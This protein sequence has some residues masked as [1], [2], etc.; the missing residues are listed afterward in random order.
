MADLRRL[1]NGIH[2]FGA[3]A[4]IH[5]IPMLS[6]PLEW[7]SEGTALDSNRLA[8]ATVDPWSA[9]RYRRTFGRT[10]ED[11]ISAVALEIRTCQTIYQGS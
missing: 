1:K 10:V 3:T 9:Q 2:S 6:L 11:H 4:R 8:G 5:E 7:S